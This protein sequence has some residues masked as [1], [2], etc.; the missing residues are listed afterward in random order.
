MRS[1]LYIPFL[2]IFLVGC[3]TPHDFHSVWLQPTPPTDDI[4]PPAGFKT[5]P[6]QAYH[7]LRVYDDTYADSGRHIW[8]IYADSRFYYFFDAI[9][10]TNASSRFAF[11]HGIKVDGY[12]D[13]IYLDDKHHYY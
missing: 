12:S 2:C 6:F 3:G 8:R 10:H 5:T 9:N 11:L 1:L 13:L 7:R 4:A